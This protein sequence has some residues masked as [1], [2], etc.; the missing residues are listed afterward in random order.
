MKPPSLKTTLLGHPLVCLPIIGIGCLLLYRWYLD[1]ALWPLGI[2]ALV[3]MNSSVNAS[4]E[5]MKYLSWKQAWD[6]LGEASHSAR[7]TI[8][9][10]FFASSVLVAMIV[11]MASHAEV[12]AY[13]TG[14]TLM[15]ATAIGGG[16]I[17]LTK[18]LRQRQRQQQS[19]VPDTVA[20]CIHSPMMPVPSLAQAFA[21]LPDHC[22]RHG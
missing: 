1:A 4:G 14:L 7:S 22:L 18:S 5:R 19:A 8:A 13:R 2:A 11:Y 17:L 9:G 12:A 21:A 16:V 10:K 20:I 6:A 3:A 15:A